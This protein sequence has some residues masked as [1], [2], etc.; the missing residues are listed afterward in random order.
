MCEQHITHPETW[1]GDEGYVVAALALFNNI[2]T[3]DAYAAFWRLQG[4]LRGS[5]PQRVVLGIGQHSS[6][7][8]VR[9]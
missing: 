1:R 6:E 9:R 3:A 2:D 8:R 7:V 5:L 4:A